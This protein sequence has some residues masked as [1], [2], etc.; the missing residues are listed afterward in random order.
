VAEGS[1][2]VWARDEREQAVLLHAGDKLTLKPTP[3]SRPSSSPRPLPPPA[4]AKISLDN[5]PIAWAVE[6]FNRVNST[7]IVVADDE[8]GAVRIVGLFKANDPQH[9]AEV[10]AQFTGANVENEDGVIFIKMK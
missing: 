7:R 8:I 10:V 9:F 4:I 2:L 5:V 3:A 1:V 6:R